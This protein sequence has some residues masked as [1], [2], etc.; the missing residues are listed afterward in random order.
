MINLIGIVLASLFAAHADAIVAPYVRS[1]NF[2]GVVLVERGGNLLVRR[3][4]GLANVE[5][6]VAVT[7]D[8]RFYIASLSKMFT[9]A[10]I[11][12]LRDAQKL[13][14]DDPLSRFLPDFPRAD[15]I[16]I[17]Q[18][19]THR[20]GLAQDSSAP[21]YA[22]IATHPF[23]LQQSIDLAAK[24]APAGEPGA[25]RVYSNVNYVLL[26][27]I[28]ERASGEPFADYLRNH[29]FTPL[30]MTSTGLHK[31]WVE[32]VPGRAAG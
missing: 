15:R 11:L 26:A 9:A 25:R 24:R 8:A 12:Q 16:S 10:A 30:H 29:L 27:T 7:T 13:A 6:N 18:L 20:S 2:S 1:N 21:D 14:L 19:L 5:H 23:T 3:A 4:Y 17:R 31:S 32:L 22:E 28:V